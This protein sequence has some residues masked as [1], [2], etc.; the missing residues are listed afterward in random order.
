M[1]QFKNKAFNRSHPIVSGFNFVTQTNNFTSVFDPKPLDVHDAACIDKLLIDSFQPGMIAEEQ[2]LEDSNRLKLITS[3]IKAI[4]KQGIVLTG[5]RV[6]QAKAILKPYKDGT[7]TK[8]IMSTFGSRRTGYNMLAYY[9]LH[10]ELS[11][12]DLREK[13]KKLPQR[14]AYALASRSGDI[15]VKAEILRDHHGRNCDELDTLIQEKLPIAS[16]DKRSRKNLNGKLIVKIRE[17]ILE[18]LLIQNAL[19]DE[20][21][22]EIVK[23]REIMDSMCNRCTLNPSDISS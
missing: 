15:Q 22:S 12:D 3:E 9:E 6:S 11:N 16:K 21:R 18:L 2:V 14:S 13:L 4:G 17:N 10:N 7:L 20:E 19:T 1:S 23:L 8:W 5:E